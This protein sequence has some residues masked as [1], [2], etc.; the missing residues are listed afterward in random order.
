M[1][2]N[3]PKRAPTARVQ[4]LVDTETAMR[5]EDARAALNR[6]G[7]P[8]SRSMLVQI[9]VKELLRRSLPELVKIMGRHGA[10]ARRDY[11]D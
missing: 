6:R 9:A 3:E 5:M 4:A 11:N 7:T 2:K 10:K 8:V 1:P